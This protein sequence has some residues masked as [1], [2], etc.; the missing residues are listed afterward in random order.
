[1]DWGVIRQ[2]FSVGDINSPEHPRHRMARAWREIAE[3]LKGTRALIL[4][5]GTDFVW[6]TWDDAEEALREIDGIIEAIERGRPPRHMKVWVLFLPTGPL[7]QVSIA[8]NWTREFGVMA[9]RAEQLFSVIDAVGRRPIR[10]PL[11]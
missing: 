10:P 3:I 8:G 9:D 5:P 6:S 11:A 1:M 4:R 7:H 2:W